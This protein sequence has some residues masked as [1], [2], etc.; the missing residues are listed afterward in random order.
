MPDP[1]AAN[2]LEFDPLAPEGDA[3]LVVYM[4]FK[5]PYAFIAKDPTFAMARALGIRIDWRPFVLDI[6][7]Y[8]GSARLDDSGKVAESNRTPEQW[9]GVRY[10]YHDARRYAKLAGYVLRGTTKIWDSSLA[11]IGMM[12][13]KGQGD[14]VLKRY[15]DITY[16][17]FWRRE[18]DIEDIHVVLALLQEAGAVR[19][20]SRG[21][22]SA[23]AATA[24][25]ARR[26]LEHEG[27]ALLEAQQPRMFDAGIFGVPT[28]VLARERFFG[29]E[30][31]PFLHWKLAGGP[32]HGS[33]TAPD[34]GYV[35]MPPDAAQD[36]TR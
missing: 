1:S 14:D 10:A 12:W 3:Q 2:A 16:E 13:A 26:Y 21:S 36:A 8:L 23:S 11:A 25:D 4:D 19:S 29:R 15:M 22:G 18:L 34:I 5:S 31:L 9:S 32:T 30:H 27:R 28:Y 35:A 24:D 7:S 6:P 33:A 17:R 20:S